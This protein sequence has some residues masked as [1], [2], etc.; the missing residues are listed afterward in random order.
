MANYINMYHGSDEITIEKLLESDIDVSLG[1]GEIGQ[2]FYRGDKMHVAKA[3]AFNKHSSESVLEIKVKEDKFWDMNP[4][5]LTY[6][7]ACNI[8]KYIRKIKKQRTYKFYENVVWSPLVG[9]QKL[10][11][12]N[13][14]G[15]QKMQKII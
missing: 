11:E 14:S 8:R 3:W 4:H 7:E 9:N 13:L 6:E 2:G 1:G 12:S 15:N 10:E 5:T